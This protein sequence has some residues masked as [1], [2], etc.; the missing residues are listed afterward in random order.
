MPRTADVRPPRSSTPVEGFA[1]LGAVPGRT[2]EEVVADPRPWVPALVPGGV[3]ESLIAAGLLAHPYR[4]RHEDD[5]RWV[6][7][8]DWWFR[9]TLA[10][11]GDLAADE[12][13][14]L[15]FAGLDTVVELWLDGRPL[16]AHQ[17]MF[18]PL[19]LDVTD[20]L[21]DGADHA[22]LLRF[23]PPL[24]GLTVPPA[25]A[26]LGQRLGAVFAQLG[27]EGDAAE[28]PGEGGGLP[29]MLPLATRRRKATFSWGWDFGPRLPSVG[30]W[31]R[32]TLVRERRAV[33]RDHHVR[34]LALTGGT[35]E[36]ELLVEVDAVV[37]APGRTAHVTLTAPSGRVLTAALPVEDG[38]ARGRLVVEDAE[39]WW[40]HDLGT[41]ALHDVRVELREG[42]DVLDVRTD[43]VGLR[44]VALD[45]AD[46][47]EGGR[48]FRFVLNGV[49]LFAR[50]AC[51][52]PADM[53]VGSV[54]AERY[55]ALVGLARDANMTMLRIWGGGVYEHD[56]FYAATD[57]LG[58]LVW[59]D[60]MFACTDYPSDD[61][62]LQ[63]EVA[64]EAEHQV[65]RLRNRASLALWSGNNEVHLI[66]GFAYQGYGPGGWGE[67][68]FHE[69]LPA[70]V[71]RFDG[72]T[73]YWPGSPWGEDSAEG[74]M[75]V[76]GVLDGDR[77]AWEVWHGF[78]FGAGGGPYDSVGEARHYR[79]YANDRGK[80]VSEFG[81]HASP[82]LATLERWVDQASLAV[83]SDAFDA[84]NKDHPKDKG[85]A[86][87]EIVTGLPTSMAEY[88]D[89]T[90]VSQAEGLK[91][92]VEH[93]R[94]R[95]PHC[96]GTLVWQLNDVWPGFSWSVVD[97]DTVPKA[98]Y[99][100]LRRAFAPV[101]A[102][103]RV[104]AA[105][106]TAELWVT[107]SGTAPVR[108]TAVVTLAG[109]DGTE[110]LRVEV[111]VDVAAGASEVVWGW[112]GGPEG[113]SADR[114][115]WVDAADG[116]FGPGRAFLAEIKDLPL[117]GGR[118]EHVVEVAGPGT[119]AVTLTSTGF[120]Y[121]V[122]VTAPDHPAARFSDNY[123][124]LRDG[125]SVTVLVTGLPADAGVGAV[126]AGRYVGTGPTLTP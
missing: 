68:F 55:R 19:V 80:F 59:H 45:R 115:L 103:F 81:L 89:F 124:D 121:L 102:S 32:V 99:Y 54:T 25:V 108:T 40:T 18:T 95:Q 125:E 74:F 65:R 6:E 116:A 76:N 43:R 110:H 91:F 61:P 13:L 52:I 2:P 114:Y 39:L 33:V 122:R 46:D 62:E 4:D 30:I 48:L 42:D 63:R 100:A 98:G 106:G 94:R 72:S 75:A 126:A 27:G 29:A 84:H 96:S 51:W 20:A 111:P 10:G 34:T 97:H 3:H 87:L 7:E 1:L 113:L 112:S 57:E 23:A 107:S 28:D 9:T 41:P 60:F 50:G 58:V 35:A 67:H 92:G 117:G 66:H 16:A 17:N 69:I 31:Q 12:R 5:A 123:L 109:F 85:D 56:A 49:P 53:M 22:L 82:A 101:L 47:P 88:V 37:A 64:A 24:A 93:Y 83:H 70:A 38:E 44:T 118:L 105:A 26:D 11:P 77:H 14:R 119:L 15:V 8:Q 79:R 73:P 71:E 36:V 104:D 86:L 78:D 21:A 90:M 120:S